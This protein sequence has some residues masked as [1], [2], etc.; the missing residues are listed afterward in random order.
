R[1][2]V[3]VGRTEQLPSFSRL[4]KGCQQTRIDIVKTPVGHGQDNVSRPKLLRKEFEKS[5]SIG[6]GLGSFAQMPQIVSQPFRTE[7]LRPRNFCHITR[8]PQH[9]QICTEESMHI[10]FLKNGT[11][12]CIGAGLE[13]RYQPPI[14]KTGMNGIARNLHGSRMMGEVIN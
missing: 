10:E 3:P 12:A 5:V 1:P 8:L 11:S 9:D 2:C 4:L 14:R 6:K 13:Y 7:S